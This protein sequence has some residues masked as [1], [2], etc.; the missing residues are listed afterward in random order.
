MDQFCAVADE[1]EE[2]EQLAI[3]DI[4]VPPAVAASPEIAEDLYAK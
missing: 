4:K 3:D 1:S 2:D